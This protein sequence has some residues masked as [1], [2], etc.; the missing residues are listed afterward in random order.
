MER[1]FPADLPWRLH[2]YEGSYFFWLWCEGAKK[3]SKEL[4]AYLK[5]Q[6]VIVVPGEYFFPGQDS[7]G[8]PHANECLRLNFARPD[9]ELESGIPIIA[10]AI[11]DAYR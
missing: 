3:T 8:W 6:K 7:A 4:Y 2:S 5:E 9:S 10:Q 1:Y 11:Q